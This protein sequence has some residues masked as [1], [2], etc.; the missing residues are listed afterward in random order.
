MMARAR[1]ESCPPRCLPREGCDSS[2]FFF[3]LWETRVALP[4]KNK[5][6]EIQMIYS[7]KLSFSH[8]YV[9]FFQRLSLFLVGNI[10]ISFPFWWCLRPTEAYGCPE[11]LAKHRQ[12]L[13]ISP[14]FVW[15]EEDN[16]QIKQLELDNV[17]LVYE[18]DH[19]SLWKTRK[20]WPPRERFFSLV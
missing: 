8:G 11:T 10:G 18:T 17:V 5:G 20:G 16:P 13:W 15:T 19:Y 3:H 12:T 2:R 4:R 6:S 7:S 9:K 1:V 14:P